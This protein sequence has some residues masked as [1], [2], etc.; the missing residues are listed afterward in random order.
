MPVRFQ[1][2]HNQTFRVN[3][4]A[5]EGVREVSAEASTRTIDIT[6]WDHK[7]A[8]TLPTAIDASLT[9]TLYYPE[10]VG[11]FWTNL[12][13]HPKVPM[14]LTIDGLFTGPFVV[15]AIKVGCPMGGVVPHDI[16]FKQYCY[17]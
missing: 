12:S 1:L 7:Y 10:E 6:G 17:Q 5:L 15:S 8:S 16:T 9:V 11:Q 4:T 3:G 13:T 14:T 2:G